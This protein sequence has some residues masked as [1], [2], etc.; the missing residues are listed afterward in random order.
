MRM[1]K[2][3]K[4]GDIEIINQKF[5]QHKKPILIK[6]VDISKIAVSNKV[7]FCKKGFKFFIGFKDTKKNRALSIFLPK[8]T[9]YRKDF[10][11]IKLCPF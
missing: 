9:P 11:E 5:H 8:M 1:E 4:L 2:F 7:S 10:E 6:N 3:V